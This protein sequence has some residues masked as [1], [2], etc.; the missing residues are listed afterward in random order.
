MGLE[1]T[2]EYAKTIIHDEVAS[3]LFND[4]LKYEMVLS[5]THDVWFTQWP[6]RSK[7]TGLGATPA[8]AFKIATGV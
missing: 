8:D 1:E 5:N 6:S 3:S 2:L 4:P 7:T